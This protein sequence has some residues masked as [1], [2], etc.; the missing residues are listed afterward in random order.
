MSASSEPFSTNHLSRRNALKTAGI[1][2]AAFAGMRAVHAQSPSA[3]L[4]RIGLIGAGGRGTGA[5]QQAL[6]AS[7]RIWQQRTP[8]PTPSMTASKVRSRLSNR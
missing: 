4:I 8:P 1:A 6:S 2:G 3:D 5:L 7:G